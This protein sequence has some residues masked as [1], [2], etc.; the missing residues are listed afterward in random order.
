MDLLPT[1][2]QEEIVGSIASVIAGNH[3]IGEP[4]DDR[5]WDAV[6][7]GLARTGARGGVRRCRVLA[8]R[9]G[10][11]VPG[12]RA[13]M[14]SGFRSSPPSSRR[15]S[16]RR[17]ARRN[18]QHASSPARPASAWL[19]GGTTRSS[20][21]STP[22][23]PRSPCSSTVTG[24]HSSISTVSH[25]STSVLRHARAGGAGH[26]PRRRS[27]PLA[28][29]PGERRRCSA[30]RRFSWR[31]C[32]PAWP[33]PRPSSRC[34]TASTGSSSTYVG[35][36]QAVKHRCADMATRAEAAM[37]QVYCAALALHATDDD[38]QFHAH[39]ARVVA[40][41][42]RDRQRPDQRAEPRWHR[43]HLGTHRTSL[44]HPVP[45]VRLGPGHHPWPPRRDACRLRTS[46][47]PT[48]RSTD[49]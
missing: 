33:E 5:L 17:P 2:E 4:L 43:L 28:T 31:R 34:R 14:R 30:G 19:S 23:A 15:G 49:L 21:S 8:R 45:G 3:T 25:S 40:A 39:A 13:C 16:L 35:G 12:A 36:F 38:A 10:P 22:R 37:C 24:S 42:T 47:S 6:G 18:W 1:S 41:R 32:L 11:A 48:R 9:G 29:A 44:R 27:A 20:R 7:T 26:R 46:L